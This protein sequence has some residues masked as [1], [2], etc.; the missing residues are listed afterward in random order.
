MIAHL[1]HAVRLARSALRD[2]T[3]KS[4]RSPQWPRVERNFLIYYPTCAACGGRDHLQ[5]HHERPYHLAPEL[6]LDPKNL[7]TLCMGMGRHCHLMLGHGDNFR[8]A[9][10][11]VRE[12][13]RR[14]KDARA[15]GDLAEVAA[16]EAAAKASRVLAL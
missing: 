10:L 9:V 3:T 15:R 16:L 6:E 11:Q 7:L 8:S 4:R 13:A 14:A 1:T 5:V 2:A 12:L